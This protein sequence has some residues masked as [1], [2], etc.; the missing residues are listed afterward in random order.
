MLM[1]ETKI[2]CSFSIG[3]LQGE[4]HAVS[5][6]SL[7]ERRRGEQADKGAKSLGKSA[8]RFH[9]IYATPLI[10]ELTFFLHVFLARWRHRMLPERLLRVRLSRDPGEF[11]PVLAQQQ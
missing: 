1:M 8:A 5:Q 11:P 4:R 10:G 9:G 6:S 7:L 3:F 2:Q